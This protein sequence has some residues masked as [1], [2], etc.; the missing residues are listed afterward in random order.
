M[1]ISAFSPKNSA[2]VDQACAVPY[3]Q[4]KTQIEFCLITSSEGRWIFPKGVVDPGETF[5]ET[6]LKEALEEAGLHGR[7]QGEPLGC[8]PIAKNGGSQTVIA[9]LME[10]LR[11]DKTWKEADMRSRR[12]VTPSA[13]ETMI[14]EPAL[15]TLLEA[16]TQRIDA[17]AAALVARKGGDI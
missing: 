7:I 17:D 6:A 8:Y 16:A 3:R 13:A 10:V 14:C 4:S 11:S 12:W 5:D 9:L 15:L 2:A 1:E